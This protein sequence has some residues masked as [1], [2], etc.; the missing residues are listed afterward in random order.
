MLLP[1]RNRLCKVLVKFLDNLHTSQSLYISQIPWITDGF[2]PVSAD[3]ELPI[4]DS[5][6]L[7]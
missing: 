4:Y 7:Q 2:I 5:A 6:L 3:T 1:C